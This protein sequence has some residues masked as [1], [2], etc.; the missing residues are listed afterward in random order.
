MKVAAYLIFFQ[1]RQTD[2]KYSNP[3]KLA[4][5]FPEIV[6]I[7]DGGSLHPHYCYFEG[8]GLEKFEYFC[9]RILSRF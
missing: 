2:D 4:M 7:K 6:L 1:T 9:D 3:R 8:E 5:D